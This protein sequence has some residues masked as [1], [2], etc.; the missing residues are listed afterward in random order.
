MSARG[1]PSIALNAIELDPADT[2]T[3]LRGCRRR[4]VPLGQRRPGVDGIQQRTAERAGEGP[5]FHAPSRL[6]R[7]AT[8]SR[9][10]WEIHVDQATMPAV[11]IYLRDSTVDSGRSSPS[12]SGVA[13]PFTFGSQTFWWQCQDIKVDA[14]TFQKPVAADVDFELFE[15]DHGVFAAGLTHENAQRNRTVRVF[16]QVHNR[17]IHAAMN[18][19][20]KVFFAASAVT[21]PDLPTGFWSGF[22]NNVVPGASAWQ[23]IGPHKVV[24]QYRTGQR[25]NHPV[26]VDRAGHRAGKR[27][28]ARGDHRRQ[29]FDFQRGA[30]HRD[31]W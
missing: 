27:Q 3:G 20:V 22:P 16:V 5:V 18:V 31:R 13:D 9:G 26:R 12:P 14:P 10:V 24:A 11:D 1:L 2:E 30:E 15:D 7:A 8:Q 6:L 25:A 19:A 17:G 4:G 23:Q 28:P 29:R 21:L